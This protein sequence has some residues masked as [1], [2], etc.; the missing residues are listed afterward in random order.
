MKSKNVI[1]QIKIIITNICRITIINTTYN[2]AG[3][4]CKVKGLVLSV[5][6]RF[7]SLFKLRVDSLC[8]V[9]GWFSL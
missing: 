7:G 2:M 5:K 6:W 4:F 3:P 8:K 9:E 1:I